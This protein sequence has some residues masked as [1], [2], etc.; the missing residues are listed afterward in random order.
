MVACLKGPTYEDK[1]SEL[2]LTI[3]EGR[4]QADM[5]HVYKIMHGQDNVDKNQ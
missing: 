2:V 4:H 3:E 1:L 5:V